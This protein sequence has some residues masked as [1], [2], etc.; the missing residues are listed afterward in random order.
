MSTYFVFC[1]VRTTYICCI[2]FF[3]SMITFSDTHT[4]NDY[5]GSRVL[6]RTNDHDVMR[7][8]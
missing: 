7:L 6:Y 1:F 5:T 3:I 4:I 8:V 2:F